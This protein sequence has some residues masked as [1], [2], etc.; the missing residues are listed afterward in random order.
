MTN[1]EPKI[2]S[3]W[4]FLLL[5]FVY[6]VASEMLNVPYNEEVAFLERLCIM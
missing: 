1:N 4:T 3:I 6:Q 5:V 2:F